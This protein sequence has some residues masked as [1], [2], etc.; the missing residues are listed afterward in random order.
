M[1]L[2]LSA[3]PRTGLTDVYVPDRQYP[4][5]YD[6]QVTGGRVSPASSGRHVLIA[7]AGAGEVRIVVRPHSGS[8]GQGPPAAPPSATPAAGGGTLATTGSVGSLPM[9][10]GVLLL[11]CAAVCRRQARWAR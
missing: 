6:V 2:R 4:G 5:G 1:D 3:K 8:A 9:A 11:A 7:A 10:A